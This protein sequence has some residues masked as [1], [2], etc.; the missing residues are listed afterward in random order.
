MTTTGESTQYI[1]LYWGGSSGYSMDIKTVA[2][3]KLIGQNIRTLAELK[4]PLEVSQ[5]ASSNSV[6][7]NWT[8]SR[9]LGL[10]HRCFGA[11]TF[12]D[13]QISSLDPAE[14]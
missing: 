13:C 1:R 3:K 4:G 8:F 6:F 12:K 7:W 14:D 5:F 11:P 9:V 2:I 10:N